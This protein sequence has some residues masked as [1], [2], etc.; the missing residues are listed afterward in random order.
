MDGSG[1]WPVHRNQDIE[2]ELRQLLGES[3]RLKCFMSADVDA[4]KAYDQGHGVPPGTAVGRHCWCGPLRL[5]SWLKHLLEHVERCRSS[6]GIY[7]PQFLD[8]P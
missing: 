7:C 2:I 6:L 1:G 3:A 5:L 4:A 8:K